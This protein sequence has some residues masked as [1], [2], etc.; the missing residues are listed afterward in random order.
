MLETRREDV[1]QEGDRL[2][3]PLC[4]LLAKAMLFSP[5]VARRLTRICFERRR[6]RLDAVPGTGDRGLQG[7]SRDC[8][9]APRNSRCLSSFIPRLRTSKHHSVLEGSPPLPGLSNS[10]RRKLA[11]RGVARSISWKASGNLLSLG[12]TLGWVVDSLNRNHIEELNSLPYAKLLDALTDSQKTRL[13]RTQ[14]LVSVFEVWDE[15]L[16]G[17]EKKRML[18]TLW[19]R[20]QHVPADQPF[21]EVTSLSPTATPFLPSLCSPL[22]LV[23]VQDWTHRSRCGGSENPSLPEWTLRITIQT[24]ADSPAETI[25]MREW[26]LDTSL[27]FKNK[28]KT[29]CLSDHL[30]MKCVEFKEEKCDRPSSGANVSSSSKPVEGEVSFVSPAETRDTAVEEDQAHHAHSN[31]KRK[32]PNNNVPSGNHHS[33]KCSKQGRSSSKEG[34]SPS[35]SQMDG[36]DGRPFSRSSFLRTWVWEIEYKGVQHDTEGVHP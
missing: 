33:P 3:F 24:Q 23:V 2:P 16:H 4:F 29:L 1:C 35:C 30:S 27:F 32:R 10:T 18:Q 9:N 20:K 21:R 11:G 19:K 14:V 26:G 8:R 36:T 5:W 31:K 28:K 7:I 13:W 12:R 17:R 15:L 34:R 6:E 22:P 25:C